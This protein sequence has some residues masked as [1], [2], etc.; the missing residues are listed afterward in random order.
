MILGGL[1]EAV[2]E[3]D[4]EVEAGELRRAPTVRLS[5][6]GKQHVLHP[7]AHVHEQLRQ[8]G[9]RAEEAGAARTDAQ[10]HKELRAPRNVTHIGHRA[11]RRNELC[12]Q[13]DLEQKD[14]VQYDVKD[15]ERL[16]RRRAVVA[17]VVL[18]E[19]ARVG[20]QDPP[21]AAFLDVRQ[22]VELAHPRHVPTHG[23]RAHWV[24]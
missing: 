17:V 2:E 14:G 10:L 20:A 12:A 6:D 5:G 9:Q 23:L 21:D 18:Q 19:A 15:D 4:V 3:A 13:A 8:R 7:E 1:V 16:Q 22:V 11:L 24:W